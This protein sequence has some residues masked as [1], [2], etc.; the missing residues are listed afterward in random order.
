MENQQTQEQLT[1]KRLRDV[2]LSLDLSQ[3]TVAEEMVRAGFSW[4]Q[5]TVAKTEAADRPIRINEVAALSHILGTDIAT[6][7]DTSETA[8]A[9]AERAAQLQLEKRIDRLSTE[10]HDTWLETV[11]LFHKLHRLQ[12]EADTLVSDSRTFLEVRTSDAVEQVK[13]IA[14]TGLNE[15]VNQIQ[16]TVVKM[17]V[18]ENAATFRDEQHRTA[19]YEPNE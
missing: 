1:G 5:T 3:Q 14:N 12:G 17:F 19:D 15:L 13:V 10:Y 7:V 11:N 4:G 6:L 8:L 9:F 18:A 16:A 2:R